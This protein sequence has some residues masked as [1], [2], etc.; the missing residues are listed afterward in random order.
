MGM[1]QFGNNKY[2][3]IDCLWFTK[4]DVS[5][6]SLISIKKTVN[7]AFFKLRGP[8]LAVSY[9]HLTLPTKRIV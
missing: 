8:L 5:D 6:D 2:F 9:T 1:R 4:A 3:L 7:K